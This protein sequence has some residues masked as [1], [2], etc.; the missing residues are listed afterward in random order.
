MNSFLKRYDFN[1]TIP[2]G[3]NKTLIIFYFRLYQI[4]VWCFRQYNFWLINSYWAETLKAMNNP[5]LKYLWWK[6]DFKKQLIKNNF[7]RTI[8]WVADLPD[9]TFLINDVMISIQCI[10]L[11]ANF[12]LRNKW[13]CL[14]SW[15]KK[16]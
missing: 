10:L 14:K 12:T 8:N 16:I 5:T 13:K 1:L 2:L 6:V 11:I 9:L 7:L 3:Y 4:S 15:N